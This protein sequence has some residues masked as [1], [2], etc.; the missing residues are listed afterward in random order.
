MKAAIFDLDG[1]L[2]N[3]SKD[4]A[5][6]MNNSLTSLGFS[7]KDSKELINYVGEGLN[8]FIKLSF[9]TNDNDLIEKAKATFADFYSKNL[10][11]YT[12]T[13]DG[14]IETLTFLKNKGLL[15]FV[16]SN[17]PSLFVKS[18]CTHFEMNHFFSE[19]FGAE[20]LTELKPDPTS[21][22]K[23]IEQYHLS[24]GEVMIVGD[25]HTDIEA[26]NLAR[27]TTVFCKY[28]LGQVRQK[29]HVDHFI[30]KFS[31]LKNLV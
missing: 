1:T 15:L 17:K 8:T 9:K 16:I 29:N 18:L 24:R 28:G 26:G 4:L 7:K 11:V 25:H 20:D 23:I 31:D 5:L 6:A 3:S 10:T 14:V 2:I 22:N 19:I 27:I 13:Y 12:S 21:I 30:E